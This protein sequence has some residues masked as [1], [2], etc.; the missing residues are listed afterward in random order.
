M[1]SPHALP[2]TDGIPTGR[3]ALLHGSSNEVYFGVRYVDGR[4][5]GPVDGRTILRQAMAF[6]PTISVEPWDEETALRCI[7]YGRA[8]DRLDVVEAVEA[9]LAARSVPEP[10]GDNDGSDSD[11][12]KGDGSETDSPSPAADDLDALSLEQLRE[13]AES[14]GL[15]PGNK[16][17]KALRRLV[18]AERAKS[19][20]PDGDAD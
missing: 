11:L 1:L 12:S 4:S 5:T 3:Y 17:E 6:G 8:N 2:R 18:R 10:T 19:E 20:T 14:L 15:T 7:E 13:L 9:W 16:Q